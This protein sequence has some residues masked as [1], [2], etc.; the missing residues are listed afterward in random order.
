MSDLIH[1]VAC[2]PKLEILHLPRSSGHETGKQLSWRRLPNTI[3][4]LH[5]RGGISDESVFFSSDLPESVTGLS[6]GHCP[7]LSMLTIRP[8]LTVCGAQLH[9]LEVVAPIPHLNVYN[10]VLDEVMDWAPNLRYLK[11]SSDFISKQIFDTCDDGELHHKNLNTLYIHCFDPDEGGEF[12]VEHV[13][14]GIYF[15]KFTSVRRLGIHER[16]GWRNFEVSKEA[17]REIDEILKTQAEEDGPTAVIPVNDA[18]VRFFGT[19]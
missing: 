14:K 5:V 17:L 3:R 11:V 9:E 10:G 4:E 2:L 13:L 6:I 7:R 12:E 16:L 8:L 15:G 18:G 1:S 19:L